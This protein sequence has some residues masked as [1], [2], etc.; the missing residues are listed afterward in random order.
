MGVTGKW[1]LPYPESDTLISVS[2]PI[3]QELAEKI[4]DAIS[5]V[6]TGPEGPA[7]ADGAPG[8]DGKGW[9]GGA[10]DPASGVVTFESTDGLGFTTADL[11]G[12]AGPEGPAGSGITFKGDVADLATLN[13]ITDAVLGDAYFVTAEGEMYAWSEA[14]EWVNL[15]A[16]QGAPGEKG[17]P[18][19][20]DDFTPEQLAGLKGEKGDQGDPGADSTVPGPQGDAFTYD[21]FTPEQLAGLK[22]EKGDPGE[23]ADTTVLDERYVTSLAE[24]TM[25]GY[26]GTR[27]PNVISMTQAE[28][29]TQVA[30]GMVVDSTL[31]V[32]V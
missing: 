32:I 3:V 12:E 21:D 24:R 14:G 25:S 18:F 8:T 20:Y 28:Y 30:L 22:G 10:Y 19:T 27:V 15:G 2:A 4:D 17:D 29:D 7:G 6:T 11:R 1:N 23:P 16:V 9:T 31:Y 13:A 5:T 26:V